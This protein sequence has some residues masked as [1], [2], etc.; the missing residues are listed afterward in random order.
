MKWKYYTILMWVTCLSSCSSFNRINS[1][2][3]NLIQLDNSSID[4]INKTL[5]FILFLNED[6]LDKKMEANSTSIQIHVIDHNLIQI[7]LLDENLKIL[8][9]KKLKGNLQD[10]YFEI[11][12][13][14]KIS[15]DYLILNA[16]SSNKTRISKLENG[17]LTVDMEGGGCILLG[18]VPIFCMDD[19]EFQKEF[20][21]LK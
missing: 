18:I 8:Q 21:N 11:N 15:F 12:R 4:S 10:G 14:Q 16:W 20:Q 9:T 19:Y 5:D 6:F 2:P 13:V 1:F 17:N 3:D 7:C